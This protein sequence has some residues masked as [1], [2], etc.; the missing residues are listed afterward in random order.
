MSANRIISFPPLNDTELFVW[1]VRLDADPRSLAGFSA[2][3]SDDE[4]ARARRFRF[5]RDRSR[6]VIGR[7]VLRALLGHFTATDPSA[8]RFTYGAHGRPELAE[9]SDRLRFNVSHSGDLAV[10]AVGRFE[11]VGVDVE[12]I[13]G[14]FEVGLLARHFFARTE[15]LAV[16]SAPDSERL[17][18]FYRCWT[19][20]EAYLKALGDGLARPL[21]AFEVSVGREE[22]VRLRAVVGDPAE[23]EH[24]S[25]L[26][27]EPTSGTVGAAAV[28]Q[29]A[30]RLRF[31]G[32]YSASA[33]TQWANRALDD[34]VRGDVTPSFRIRY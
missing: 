27:F 31:C 25:I 8:I 2:T 13:T 15:V 24:W 29:R 12:H 28:R 3:L 23:A 33:F 7:G 4:H 30:A 32:L 17:H 19:R 14:G 16:L 22:P 20:K 11:H 34:T 1:A 5:P 9:P 18:A 26:A 10:Y 21:D 6:Y